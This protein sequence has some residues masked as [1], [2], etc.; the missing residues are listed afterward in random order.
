M[1]PANGRIASMAF[2]LV[3]SWVVATSIGNVTPAQ[4][5][6]E[7]TPKVTLRDDVVY[8]RVQGEGTSGGHRVP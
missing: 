7:A 5:A 6:P 8:G 2:W 3:A 1:K 4:G